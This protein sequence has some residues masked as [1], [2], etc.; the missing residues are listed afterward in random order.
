MFSAVFMIT[1]AEGL[2]DAKKAEFAGSL[3]SLAQAISP[4]YLAEPTLEP[5]MPGGDYFC[6]LGFKDEAAY[7][8]AKLTQEW[9]ALQ[10]LLDDTQTVGRYEFVAYGEGDFR[11][12]ETEHSTCH[13]VLIFSLIEDADPK[14]IEKM[15]AFTCGMV[16]FV[17]GLRN[18]KLAKVIESTGSFDWAYAFEC[19]FDEPGSF[20]GKYMTTPYHFTYVDKFFEPA[21]NEWIV[22]P[23]LCTPY[24]AQEKPFLANFSE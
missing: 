21:C 20:L 11:F 5:P 15:E 1:L 4:V 17:P 24:C 13:R 10:S 9:Q 14:M 12:Q 3:A 7:A 16:D 23:G 8:A 22:D 2:D 19:D 6:E 18:C